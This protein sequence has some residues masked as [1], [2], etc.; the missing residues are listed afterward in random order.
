[1][2]TNTGGNKIIKYIGWIGIAFI[3]FFVALGLMSYFG[4]FS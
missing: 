2:K 3:S 1:M 4:I